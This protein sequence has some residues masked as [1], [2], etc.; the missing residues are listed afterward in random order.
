MWSMKLF[1]LISIIVITSLVAA[2]TP[3]DQSQVATAVSQAQATVA[4]QAQ[5]QAAKIVQ[6]KVVEGGDYVKTQTTGIQQTAVAGVATQV[7]SIQQTAVAGIATQIAK[8]FPGGPKKEIDYFALGDSI[9]SGHGLHST[10]DCKR[11]TLSYP[12]QVKQGLESRGMKIVNFKHVACSGA[13]AETP[14]NIDYQNAVNSGKADSVLKKDPENQDAPDTRLFLWLHT[15]VKYVSANVNDDRDTLVTISIGAN[16]LDWT[17]KKAL[18]THLSV[19]FSKFHDWA[20]QKSDDIKKEITNSL[21]NPDYGL[22]SH[23]PRVY[24]IINTIYNPITPSTVY[25]YAQLGNL[26]YIY[27]CLFNSLGNLSCYDRASDLL[28]LVNLGI[29]TVVSDQM[30]AKNQYKDSIQI[31]NVE[32]AF[33]AH[34]AVAYVCDATLITEKDKSWVQY[35]GYPDSNEGIDFVL[36]MKA[37]GD[38]FHPNIEGAKGIADTVLSPFC[39]AGHDFY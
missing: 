10:G 35:I 15:Q 12:Y 28:T 18:F 37:Q 11:S 22:M 32:L 19:D 8:I 36:G 9:A 13:T 14:D 2:C 7:A 24:V 20:N 27:S 4:V 23:H 26:K 16:D 25:F 1:R 5:T 29:I 33:E 3:E 31:A 17:D 21:F 34:Q 39:R 30:R 6:T 38:C